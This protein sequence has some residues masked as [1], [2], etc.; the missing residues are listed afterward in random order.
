MISKCSVVSDSSVITFITTLHCKCGLVPIVVGK[1][2]PG[3]LVDRVDQR[4]FYD[5][6]SGEDPELGGF[7]HRIAIVNQGISVVVG[8]HDLVVG[9]VRKLKEVE[10]DIECAVENDVACAS[11]TSAR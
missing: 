9:L 10:A 5:W 1:S 7:I 4:L 2:R 3:L 8:V 6:F 11:Q